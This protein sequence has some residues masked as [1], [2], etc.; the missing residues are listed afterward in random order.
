MFIMLIVMMVSWVF[1]FKLIILPI[2]N[3]YYLLYVN[4]AVLKCFDSW[5]SYGFFF[6]LSFFCSNSSLR[7]WMPQ[8][9]GKEYKDMHKGINLSLYLKI[10]Y[11][12]QA[13]ES[14]GGNS[15]QMVVNLAVW[16]SFHFE[17]V[18]LISYACPILLWKC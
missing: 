6:S 10:H 15:V 7:P 12:I 17:R 2:F 3:T 9:K 4:K 8:L 11:V 5:N 16:H 13:P 1:M 18:L 14:S